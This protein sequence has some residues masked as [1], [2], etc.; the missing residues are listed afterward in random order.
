MPEPDANAM[1]AAAV[2]SLLSMPFYAFLLKA[3]G[4]STASSGALW[5]FVLGVFFDA[6]LNLPHSF[7]EDRPFK[8]FLVH[9]GYHVCSLMLIGGLLGALSTPSA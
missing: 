8:L 5:G 6:G 2:G 3:V 4:C 7:F 1:T 9:R